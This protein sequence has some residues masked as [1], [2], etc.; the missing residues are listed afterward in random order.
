MDPKKL[1][2]DPSK[3]RAAVKE[4]PDGRLVAVKPVKIYIP[5][6]FTERGLAEIGIKTYIVGIYAIVLDDTHYGVSSI[7]A[8]LQITPTS[9]MKVMI[10]EEEYYEFSFDAGSVITPSVQLVKKDTLV[11]R[12]YDE[13]ISKGR[14]PWYLD[15][16]DLGRLFDTA[17]YH[18][19]ARIGKNHE[20]TELIVS[21]IAR[22]AKDRHQYYRAV[23]K[24]LDDMKK[25]PP[26]YIPLRSVIYAPT[27]TT[28]KL[29]GSYFSEGLVS[30]LVSPA[31]RVER[32]EGLLRL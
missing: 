3:V 21:L 28:N 24:S 7:N 17:E 4:L 8:Q 16:L 26:A 5:S 13:I 27:N 22:N 20:V 1:I 9:T 31:E 32:I 10:N 29:A 18:A 6:R 12:I 23:P 11:Y 30:A 14:V 19:G 2:R 15:Y 25:N